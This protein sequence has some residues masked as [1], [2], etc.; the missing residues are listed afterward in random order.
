[1]TNWEE[2]VMAVA[3]HRVRSVFAAVFA[4]ALVVVLAAVAAAVFNVRLPI[5]SSITDAMGLR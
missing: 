4:L 3:M 2:G 1:M 5:L